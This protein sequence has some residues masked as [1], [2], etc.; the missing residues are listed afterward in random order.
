MISFEGYPQ[1]NEFSF[2]GQKC[3][4]DKKY[5]F[6]VNLCLIFRVTPFLIEIKQKSRSGKLIF[7]WQVS[8]LYSVQNGIF[9]RLKTI[10]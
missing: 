1:S 5:Q 6:Q 10:L 7:F 3:D 8:C 4:F 9:F 2:P